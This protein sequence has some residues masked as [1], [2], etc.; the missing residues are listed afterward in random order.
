VLPAAWACQSPPRL[1]SDSTAG[2][3]LEEEAAEEVL[4]AAGLV[5]ASAD[6]YPT[7]AINALMRTLRDLVMA[8]HHAEVVR[9]L[10]YIF[11]VR[12]GFHP[13]QE[14]DVMALSCAEFVRALFL[15]MHGGL[16][17]CMRAEVCESAVS[18]HV[19]IRGDCKI[20]DFPAGVGPQLGAISAKGADVHY[21][22]SRCMRFCV[23]GPSV[24]E[25]YWH[26]C[27]VSAAAEPQLLHSRSCR[28]CLR[29]CAQ[30]TKRCDCSCSSGDRFQH[31]PE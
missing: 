27:M 26:C 1:H 4:P 14:D 6:Y 31:A 2:A 24:S 7:V 10:F 16:G 17:L 13:N 5:T 23:T 15:H 28:S 8:P 9:A 18:R 12:Q 30:R 11:T 19:C 3:V 29:W 20:V 22:D 25:R 21:P